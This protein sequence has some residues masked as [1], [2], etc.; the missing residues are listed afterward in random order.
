MKVISNQLVTGKF[1]QSFA[2]IISIVDQAGHKSN[3]IKLGVCE[4][5]EVQGTAYA[6]FGWQQ[7]WLLWSGDNA[8]E[9][10]QSLSK[11][12][13]YALGNSYAAKV[14][15]MAGDAEDIPDNAKIFYLYLLR[16]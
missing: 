14:Q 11:C 1:E 2:R 8:Y 13:G 4:K 3:G 15:N 7:M 10:Q 16:K 12:I 6:S 5:P 9:A